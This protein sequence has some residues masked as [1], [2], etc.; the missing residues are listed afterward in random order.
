M[1]WQRVNIG[2]LVIRFAATDRQAQVNLEKNTC[3]HTDTCVHTY[4]HAGELEESA[5][6][7]DQCTN[8]KV[9]IKRCT[10]NQFISML[11]A[12][13]NDHDR[14]SSFDNAGGSNTS[15]HG[16]HRWGWGE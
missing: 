10:V 4:T 16:L 12:Y 15:H 1:K 7:G 11:N 9:H 8:K 14:R 2:L 6:E 13:P 5:P 3:A